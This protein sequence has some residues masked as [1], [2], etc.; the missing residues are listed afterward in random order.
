M[1]TAALTG[2]MTTVTEDAATKVAGDTA[3]VDTLVSQGHVGQDQLPKGSIGH[4]LAVSEPLVRQI[5]CK[6]SN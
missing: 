3:A 6:Q 2:D 4:R 1:G 5:T